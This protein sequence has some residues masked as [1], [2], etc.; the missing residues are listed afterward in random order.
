MTTHRL[1]RG[2]AVVLGAA[3]VPMVAVGVFG[4][5]GSYTNITAEFRRAGTAAGAVAAGEGVTLVLALVMLGVTML[6]QTAPAALRAGLWLAP[7]TGCFTGI[8]VADS[9]A[10]AVIYATTPLA[11]SGAAEGLGFIARRVVVYRTGHDTEAQRR[12]AHAVQQLA[13]HQ[14]LA[15]GHPDEDVREGSKRKAWK[16]IGRLGGDDPQL[17]AGLI[18]VQRERLRQGADSALAAMLTARPPVPDA[19]PRTASATDALRRKFAT[20][21]PAAAIRLA[22]E[23]RPD[24]PPA[25]LAHLLGTYDVHVDPVAVALVLGTQPPEYDVQRGDAPPHQQV[26]ALQPVTLE[27]AIVEAASVL[28][29]GAKAKDIVE[30]VERFRRLVVTEAYVRTALSRA[31][32]QATDDEIG[33]G[34][35][36]YN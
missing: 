9:P 3:A 34:G 14:A 7:V 27:A 8:A 5:W 33:K 23:A 32:R 12:S 21:D 36:G 6:G 31:R 18:E 16:L 11:M 19:A 35:Q 26:S 13:L 30:H 29:E 4:A 25:E 2:Q 17:A 1:S 28:G 10:E 24:A 15:A 22:H 20:M